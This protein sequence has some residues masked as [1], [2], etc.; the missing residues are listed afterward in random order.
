MCPSGPPCLF[1]DYPST[2][3][4]ICCHPEEGSKKSSRKP[5]YEMRYCWDRDVMES[6]VLLVR[7]SVRHEYL[8]PSSGKEQVSAPEKR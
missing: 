2:G 1:N 7:M 5:L 6:G 3:E 8:R 4:A